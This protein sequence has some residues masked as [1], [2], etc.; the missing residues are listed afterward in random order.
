MR[1]G[2]NRPVTATTTALADRR[3]ARRSAPVAVETP[4]LEVLDSKLQSPPL[5]E[6]LVSR[7]ALV[8]RLRTVRSAPLVLLVAPAGYGKTTVLAQWAARDER[9]FAWMTIDERDNDPLVL[10]RHLARALEPVAPVD[11]SVIQALEDPEEPLWERA[12][13]RLARA[14]AAA[15]EPIVLVIDELQCLRRGESADIIALLLD[16]VP[17]GS[18]LALGCRAEPPLPVARLRAA[19]R[20]TEFGADDLALTR[21][22]AE[23]L[24]RAAGRNPDADELTEL[25]GRSEGWAAGLY[26]VALAAD[27]VLPAVGGDDRYLADY[28]HEECLGGLAPERLAFLRQSAVLETLSGPMC[29]AV[30]GRSE[31]GLELERLADEQ[32]FVVRLDR[33]RGSYRYHSLFRELLASDLTEHERELVPTL[34]RRAADWFEGC[35]DAESA[36][37]HTRACGDIDRAARLLGEVAFPAYFSGRADTVAEW[38]EAFELATALDGHPATAAHGAYVH[39]LQGHGSDAARWLAA[40]D[41]GAPRGRKAAGA[42]PVARWVLTLRAASCVGGPEA[43]LADVNAA[44]TSM[45]RDSGWFSFALLVRGVALMLA[46]NPRRA[47]TVLAGAAEAGAAVGATETRALALAQRALL[48]SLRDDH[49]SADVL[50]EEAFSTLEANGLRA[51]PTA[52]LA[53]ATRARSEFRLS[54]WSEARARLAEARAL[55]AETDVAFRWLS[56]QMRLELTRVAVTLRD[57]RAARATLDEAE[58]LLRL[59]PPLGVLGAQAIDVRQ[60]VAGILEPDRA[61]GYGLTG[62]ELR[63]LPLL[64]T[65]L[66]FREIGDR[67]YVSRNTIKTQAIS[68]YRKLGVSSRSDAIDRASSLGLV[69]GATASR[70]GLMLD[71]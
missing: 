32:L 60:E 70:S 25:M 1:D 45:P 35:G 57:A 40:A 46:G 56:V 19:G 10:L 63:L 14:F 53:L 61:D 37:T 22:E 5:R 62:A 29:D 8:N 21:R 65:H 15:P 67:L 43:M 18:L 11:A 51:Y 48:A 44:L 34:H 27:E 52:A 49:A 41:R 36:L 16:Q 4:G 55:A 59:G 6:G 23:L 2:Q 30:L 28:F 50:S 54:H 31:S 66:S 7:T 12:L 3:R 42:P 69:D 64:G 26:L 20:L 58:L 17:A 13:P 38:L 39:T 33:S 9:P 24:L 68:V 71:G 47:D